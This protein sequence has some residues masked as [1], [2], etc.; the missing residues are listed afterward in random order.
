[1]I[2][3]TQFYR[4]VYLKDLATYKNTLLK[5]INCERIEAGQEPITDEQGIIDMYLDELSDYLK[6]KE[7]GWKRQ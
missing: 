5:I 2:P 3:V 6:E 1:M 7:H 4:D